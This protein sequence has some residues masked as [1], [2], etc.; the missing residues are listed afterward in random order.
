[1]APPAER[2]DVRTF[3]ESEALRDH[4]RLPGILESEERSALLTEEPPDAVEAPDDMAARPHS[5]WEQEWIAGLR[6]TS[7]ATPSD[8]NNFWQYF[9]PRMMRGIRETLE[10]NARHQRD[11][12]PAFEFQALDPYY[13]AQLYRW[14]ESGI[15]KEAALAFGVDNLERLVQN[16]QMIEAWEDR[17][18]RGTATEAER[19]MLE[20]T[21]RETSDLLRRLAVVFYD[22]GVPASRI[23]G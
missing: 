5:A 4:F 11:G 19:A 10:R 16:S 18:T 9:R 20:T 1:M 7:S 23:F 3:D 17:K 21:W 22:L 13:G 2:R 15:L 14:V 6:S 12:D 8:T